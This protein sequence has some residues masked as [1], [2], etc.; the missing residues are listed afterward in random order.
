[1]KFIKTQIYSKKYNDVED[2]AQEVFLKAVMKSQDIDIE[3]HPNIKGWLISI[4]KNIIKQFNRDYMK[5]KYKIDTEVDVNSVIQK[6]FTYQLIEDM[7]YDDIDI[8]KFKDKLIQA[9]SENDKTLYIMKSKGL[10]N[11]EI[12]V[13]LNITENAVSS[14][15]KRIKQKLKKLYEE[16]TP[17]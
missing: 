9:L 5:N 8:N 12:S 10:S 11:R 13:I 14:R 15:F 2:C 6:D 1:M 16:A 3:N 17:L 7:I 4:A